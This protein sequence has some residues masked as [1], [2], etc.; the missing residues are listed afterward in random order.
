MGTINKDSETNILT[1]N[2][3]NGLVYTRSELQNNN[4]NITIPLI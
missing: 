3:R 4:K 2:N 1:Q